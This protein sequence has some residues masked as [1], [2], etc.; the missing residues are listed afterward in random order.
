M[1]QRPRRGEL[2]SV[3]R[4]AAL[5]LFAGLALGVSIIWMI[6]IRSNIQVLGQYPRRVAYV[7]E[8]SLTI[9]LHETQGPLWK[10]SFRTNIWRMRDAWWPGPNFN[11]WT[12]RC[13]RNPGW[14][15]EL[16]CPI[17]PFVLSSWAALSLLVFV[18]RGRRAGECQNCGYSVT[19]LTVP[20]CPECGVSIELP[21]GSAYAGRAESGRA[22]G[23]HCPGERPL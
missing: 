4:T 3:L 20:R 14:Y 18:R 10:W 5:I 9:W 2:R 7:S 17:W 23:V 11:W 16:E 13:W 12:W 22:Q 8:G 6:S 19:G 15:T 21:A 1:R